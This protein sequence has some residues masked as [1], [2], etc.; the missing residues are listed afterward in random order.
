MKVIPVLQLVPV[1][2]TSRP[3][4]SWLVKYLTHSQDTRLLMPTGKKGPTSWGIL[5]V[6][7]CQLSSSQG[8]YQPCYSLCSG[9]PS[10]FPCCFSKSDFSLL[11]CT[12]FCFRKCGNAFLHRANHGCDQPCSLRP[13]LVDS[14]VHH[15]QHHL[16]L[17][18]PNLVPCCY[19]HS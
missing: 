17:T 18:R 13:H 8:R 6:V 12:T 4:D 7:N 1:I 10:I 3:G 14:D 9:H 11:N 15:L 2:T 5:R 19:Q 16:L